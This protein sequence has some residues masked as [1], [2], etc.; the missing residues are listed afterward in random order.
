METV[1][2]AIKQ[3]QID[4]PIAIKD[5]DNYFECSI[6]TNNAV[7]Y[8]RLANHKM[9]NAGNKS[10]VVILPDE[11]LTYICEKRVASGGYFCCGLYC[12]EDAQQFYNYATYSKPGKITSYLSYVSE[13]ISEMNGVSVK[14]VDSIT[15]HGIRTDNYVD[16]GTYDDWMRHCGQYETLFVD[17]DGILVKNSGQYTRPYWGTTD[18]LEDNIKYLQERHNSGYVHIILTTSR[19]ETAKDVTLA[20]LHLYKIPFDKIIWGL[21]HC[22]RVLINDYARTNPYPSAYSINLPRDA[23]ILRDLMQ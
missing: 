11:T 18:G 7:A 5:C 6:P 4:G 3:M 2:K 8:S 16:W 13:V 17:I 14:N 1:A 10:Y 22:R 9:I 20:Q 12:F 23:D 15:F 19:K 21:P